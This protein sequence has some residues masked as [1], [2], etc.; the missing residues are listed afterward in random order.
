MTIAMALMAFM[1]TSSTRGMEPMELNKGTLLR[2]P[3]S[4]DFK[5]REN[6]IIK[7]IRKMYK[8]NHSE[9][10]NPLN[11]SEESDTWKRKIFLDSISGDAKKT[12]EWHDRLKHTILIYKEVLEKRD[13]AIEKL[14]QEIKDLEQ[15]KKE[16][17]QASYLTIKELKM[18]WNIPSQE[19]AASERIEP[20]DASERIKPQE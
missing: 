11:W 15:R 5:I 10:T 9:I 7:K 13:Q 1:G 14:E 20:Q 12:S 16:Q 4:E 17:K 19:K 8:T 3:Q 6:S 18:L 2:Q